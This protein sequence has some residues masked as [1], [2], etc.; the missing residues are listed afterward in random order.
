[1]GEREQRS[2]NENVEVCY[3]HMNR[4]KLGICLG[5]CVMGLAWVILAV[6]PCLRRCLRR[7]RIVI[8]T[9]YTDTAGPSHGSNKEYGVDEVHRSIPV[10]T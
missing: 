2:R 4:K 1:M 8:Q 10:L 3:G 9:Q 6:I 7:P 5:R